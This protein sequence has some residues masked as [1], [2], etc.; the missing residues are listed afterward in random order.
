MKMKRLFHLTKEFLKAIKGDVTMA[1]VICV[2]LAIVDGLMTFDIIRKKKVRKLVGRQ[3]VI[4]GFPE[5]IT[6]EKLREE[7]TKEE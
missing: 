2:A 6:D 7:L 3:L 1:Y 5:L 4:M